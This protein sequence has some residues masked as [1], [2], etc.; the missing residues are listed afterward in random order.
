[1]DRDLF[2]WVY[3]LRTNSCVLKFVNHNME[4]SKFAEFIIVIEN[5]AFFKDQ[6]DASFRNSGV[7]HSSRFFH[8]LAAYIT[9]GYRVSYVD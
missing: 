1:M 6:G 5:L 4:W 8:S 9:L 2:I 3:K 7:V